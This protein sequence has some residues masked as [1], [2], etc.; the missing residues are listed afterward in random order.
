MLSLP[1][2]EVAELLV[3]RYL[4]NISDCSLITIHLLYFRYS[5][6]NELRRLKL[7]YVSVLHAGSLNLNNVDCL[8]LVWNNDP[9]SSDNVIINTKP[10]VCAADICLLVVMSYI[11]IILLGPLKLTIN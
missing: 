3:A 7:V 10:L 1:L 11:I 4:K 8:E 9:K 5:A 2:H 6:S